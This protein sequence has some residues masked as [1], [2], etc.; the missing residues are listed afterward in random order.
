MIFALLTLSS[1]CPV[2]LVGQWIDEAKSKLR[3]PALVYAYHG[4]KRTKDPH[5]LAQ[6]AIIVTT[7]QTLGS[8]LRMYL[9]KSQDNDSLP[10]PAVLRVRWWRVIFDESHCIKSTAGFNDALNRLDAENKWLVTGTFT[11]RFRVLKESWELELTLF[12]Y[13]IVCDVAVHLHVATASPWYR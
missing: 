12:R 3:D 8:D 10:F 4:S 2:S 5:V 13:S 11:S 9:K 1:K 7:Y 6:N